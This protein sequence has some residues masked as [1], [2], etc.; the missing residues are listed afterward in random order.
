MTDLRV[1]RFSIQQYD[2]FPR[3][4]GGP[5]GP[6]GSTGATGA[7]STGPT[8]TTGPGITGPT[9]ATGATGSQGPTG[10]SGGPAGPTGATGATGPTG[11][12]G[13]TG[14]TGPT[15]ATS[16]VVLQT[17][18]GNNGSGVVLP[19]A[20]ETTIV[21][22]T[23]TGVVAGQNIL[24]VADA[25]IDNGG[26][27]QAPFTLALN[28]GVGSDFATANENIAANVD[29]V[30]PITFKYTPVGTGSVTI[31]LRGI[32]SVGAAALVPIQG[33][34]LLLMLVSD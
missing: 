15:G 19:A 14:V 21:S 22:A 13:S 24:I 25:E 28:E 31:N 23:V 33:G 2:Q 26:V 8:G 3:Q 32:T 17:Q 10:S 29:A 1:P 11:A 27:A 34:K 9:G 4:Q 30:V 7:G 18:F 6:T 16:G 20:T 12:T 5:Q